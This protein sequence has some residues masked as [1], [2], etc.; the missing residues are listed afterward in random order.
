MRNEKFIVTESMTLPTVTAVRGWLMRMTSALWY[1]TRPE[2]RPGLAPLSKPHGRLLQSLRSILEVVPAAALVLDTSNN[3][4]WANGSAIQLLGYAL[5]EILGMPIESFIVPSARD[6]RPISIATMRVAQRSPQS[7]TWAAI[8]HTKS[9]AHLRAKATMSASLPIGP[10]TNVVVVIEPQR[11]EAEGV[12]AASVPQGILRTRES[13]LGDIAV[14]ISHEVDQPLTAI[15]SNAQAAQRFLAQ[16]PP[17]LGD[18]QELLADV[19]ADSTRAHAIIRRMRQ[20][21]RGET[22]GTSPIAVDGLVR[23]VIQLL[24]R[25]TQT[26][27]A[28]V[29][30]RIEDGLPQLRGDAVQIQQVLVN[31]LRNALDAVRDRPLEQRRIDVSVR[32][33]ED[34]GTVCIDVSDQGVGVDDDRLGSLFMP[35]VT[36]K[37]QGLGLG[38]AISRSIVMAHDGKLWVERNADR[39]LTFHIELPSHSGSRKPVPAN[40]RK[41]T[42][43]T[44]VRR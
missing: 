16:N 19:V 9:G 4:I 31:L 3:V 40:D 11:E 34:R 13:E 18:L 23:D 25:E 7:M 8:A 36:S 28:K 20:S 32:A 12:P 6:N 27:G 5:E 22:A 26:C 44:C 35:F 37:P 15:L 14:A 30:A 33:I 21:A 39:G 38:L 17:A 1:A 2:I 29:F 41:P 42:D 10:Q 24:R 43:A